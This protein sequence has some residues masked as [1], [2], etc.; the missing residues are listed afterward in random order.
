[1]AAIKHVV[2]IGERKERLIAIEETRIF[3]AEGKDPYGQ[4]WGYRAVRVRCDCGQESVIHLS[5]WI[6]NK[7]K[8]CRCLKEEKA[9]DRLRVH[10]LADHP[11]Y[12][13]WQNMMDRCYNENHAAYHNYGGRGIS[14]CVRWHQ[15]QHFVE[16]L[17]STIG[18]NPDTKIWSLDR[19]NNNGNYE[20]G[21]VR[22]ATRSEQIKNQRPK[23]NSGY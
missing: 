17:E 1:M 20:P 14:V 11:L 22:W 2:V 5:N 12:R 9:A 21:N 10:G 13:A 7:A 6:A 4:R 15:V 16:D 18:H 8:S 3:P 19:A 23:L